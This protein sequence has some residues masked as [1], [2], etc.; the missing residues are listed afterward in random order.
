MVGF[1]LYSMAGARFHVVLEPE[2]DVAMFVP[3][4]RVLAVSRQVMSVARTKR[5]VTLYSHALPCRGSCRDGRCRGIQ[6]RCRQR[7]RR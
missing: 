2:L 7:W 1:Q 6:R 4:T 5:R 3:V